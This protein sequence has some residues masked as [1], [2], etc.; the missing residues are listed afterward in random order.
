M[1]NLLVRVARSPITKKV[2]VAV[3]AVLLDRMT[4]DRD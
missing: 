3:M 1:W 4:D 2:I